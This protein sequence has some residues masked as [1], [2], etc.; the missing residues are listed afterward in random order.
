MAGALV[1]AWMGFHAAAGLLALVTAIAGATAG[2]NLVLIVLDMT[3][4]RAIGSRFAAAPSPPA[5][6]SVAA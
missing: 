5:S 4:E 1:V 2:A 6:S 3:W